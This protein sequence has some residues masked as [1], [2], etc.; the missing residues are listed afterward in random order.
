MVLAKLYSNSLLVVFNSRLRIAGGRGFSTRL[1]SSDED[2]ED[3]APRG[4]RLETL[5]F[6]PRRTLGDAESL[7]PAVRLSGGDKKGPVRDEVCLCSIRGGVGADSGI[8]V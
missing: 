5:V 3:G 6:A 2:D 1:P 7:P 8:A 4:T